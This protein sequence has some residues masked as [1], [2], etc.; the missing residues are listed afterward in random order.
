MDPRLETNRSNWDDRVAIHTQ[1]R[2][3]DVNGWLDSSPGPLPAEIEALG[4]VTGLDII[5]LQ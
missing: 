1:S 2:F 5:H 4:D 3:Y